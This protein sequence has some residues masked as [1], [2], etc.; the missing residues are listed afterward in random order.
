MARQPLVNIVCLPR[1]YRRPPVCQSCHTEITTCPS[2]DTAMAGTQE[3]GV[4]TLIATDMIR[5]AWKDT[6][7]IAVL[8]TSDADMLPCVEYLAQREKKVVQARFPP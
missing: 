5:L 1:Q 3:K 4:D 7:A 2:C 8:A 6:Y